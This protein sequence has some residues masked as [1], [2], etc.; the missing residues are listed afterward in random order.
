MIKIA[1][2]IEQEVSKRVRIFNL[3][4]K[5]A[6][7]EKV[8]LFKKNDFIAFVQALRALLRVK[9]FTTYKKKNQKIKLSD[10]CVSNDFKSDDDVS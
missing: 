2:M 7:D 4:I 3:S 10:I 1:R 5:I 6:R 8:R 9:V